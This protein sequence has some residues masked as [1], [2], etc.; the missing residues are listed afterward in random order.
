MAQ[1][2]KGTRRAVG[3]IVALAAVAAVFGIEM[4]ESQVEA[5]KDAAATVAVGVG[6]LIAFGKELLGKFQG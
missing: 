5:A 3:A 1:E 2:K 6:G 4:D